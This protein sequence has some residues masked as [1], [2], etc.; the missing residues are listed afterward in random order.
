MRSAA[1]CY[2]T[3]DDVLR[4]LRESRADFHAVITSS[5]ALREQL[6]QSGDLF[7]TVWDHIERSSQGNPAE[8]RSR[9]MVLTTLLYAALDW[10]FAGLG[11]EI[12]ADVQIERMRQDEIHGG[13]DADDRLTREHWFVRL[14]HRLARLQQHSPAAEGYTLQ[15][16][17]LTALAQAALEAAYRATPTQR[18]AA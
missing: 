7:K 11:V 13:T 4:R 8:R 17:K 10:Q 9:L 16:I 6:F 14:S 18:L 5:I 12:E 2:S 15:L 3:R 1:N